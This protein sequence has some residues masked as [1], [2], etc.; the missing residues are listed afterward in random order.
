MAHL[1][2]AHLL[3]WSGR[4]DSLV[5][6]A[7]KGLEG[8]GSSLLAELA[9]LSQTFPG[10]STLSHSV[11]RTPA[12]ENVANLASELSIGLEGVVS[13]LLILGA[14]YSEIAPVDSPPELARLARSLQALA[15]ELDF[16]LA[17]QDPDWVFLCDVQPPALLARPVD[18]SATLEAELFSGFSSVVVTSATLRVNESFDFFFRRSGLD[19]A[20][21][22]QLSLSSPFDAASATFVGLADCGVEPN[23][24]EFPQ[25]LAPHLLELVASLQGR[26]FLL[27][28]SHRRLREFARLLQEPLAAEGV[29]LLV[30]GQAPANQL[31]RRFCSPGAYCLLG[32]DTFWEGVDI[33]GERLSCV[34]LTRLPFPVPAEPLFEARSRR[35]QE[36]GGDP[37]YELSLPLA[38]LKLKQGFGRLL[39]SQ[40]DR[41]IFLLLDPRVGRKTYGRGLARHLPGGHARRGEAADLV[42]E[43]LEWARANLQGMEEVT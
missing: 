35:I 33:P 5:V 10:V 13:H 8:L 14:E 12:G 15:R 11:L 39:R 29:Q 41:G 9:A 23:D 36:R 42:A 26:T 32:V 16:L 25:A 28:T 18:N 19:L 17:A 31:L 43:A 2:E 3:D 4:F 37:F 27:T 24:P 7:L 20:P 6:L 1:P 30:Q 21:T 40:G 22:K 34:V 38:A